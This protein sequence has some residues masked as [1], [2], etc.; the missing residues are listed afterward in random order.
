[1]ALKVP[2]RSKKEQEVS[3]NDANLTMVLVLVQDTMI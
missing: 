2:W 3:G 1:M